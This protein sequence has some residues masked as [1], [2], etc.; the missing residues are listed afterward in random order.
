MSF[1]FATY[2]SGLLVKVWFVFIVLVLEDTCRIV[3]VL[4][5]FSLT[6]HVKAA[7][8]FQGYS[9]STDLKT[10]FTFSFH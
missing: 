4:H 8:C 2:G 7:K 6:F 9:R 3:S 5:V 10:S 1:S